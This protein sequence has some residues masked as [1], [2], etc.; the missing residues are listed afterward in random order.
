MANMDFI[1]GDG[2]IHDPQRAEY[3][4]TYLGNLKKACDENIPIIGY[5]YWSF[6]DNFEWAEGYFQRFGLVYVDYKTQER[7]L[8][9][10]AYFYHEIIKTN[11]ENL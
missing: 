10:S 4:R 1:Y 9:D 3:L 6:M 7:I 11:G 2:K 5:S 8:K